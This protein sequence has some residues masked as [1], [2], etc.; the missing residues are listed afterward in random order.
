MSEY[1]PT[2]DPVMMSMFER[3][4]KEGL[5]F[6]CNYQDLWFSPDELSKR[7]KRGEFR[8]GPVNWELRCPKEHA[9]ALLCD[10]RLKES[11]LAEFRARAG[12]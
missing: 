8:W 1:D 7:H 2:N 11:E 3:A 12:L 6:W 10:I 9:A 4:R 5:W